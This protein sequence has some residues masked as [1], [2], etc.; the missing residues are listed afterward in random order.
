MFGRFVVLTILF[1]VGLIAPIQVQAQQNCVTFPQPPNPEAEL[2]YLLDHPGTRVCPSAPAQHPRPAVTVICPSRHRQ[3]LRIT[4]AWGRPERGR[5][6][7]LCLATQ[8]P[9]P[10]A[11]LFLCP[12]SDSGKP[13]GESGVWVAMGI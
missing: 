7:Q 4:K 1:V 8:I 2:R 3:W 5:S 6:P 9:Q 10:V 11:G 13:V 12:R